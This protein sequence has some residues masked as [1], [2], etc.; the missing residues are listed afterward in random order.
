MDTNQ[1]PDMNIVGSSAKQALSDQ[2][3]KV[4]PY[5]QKI[6]QHFRQDLTEDDVKNSQLE[7]EE[8]LKE[9]SKANI[10]ELRSLAKPHN[11]VE[12]VM[13]IVCALKGFKT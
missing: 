10:L 7:I 8:S 2:E 3:P 6:F 11:L 1:S 4:N 13:Q 5:D 9:I 12:K